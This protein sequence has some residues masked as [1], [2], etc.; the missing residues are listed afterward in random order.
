ML[1]GAISFVSAVTGDCPIGN[2]CRM[3]TLVITPK[4]VT[5]PARPKPGGVW[6]LNTMPFVII[7]L[8]L[9][10]VIVTVGLVV[11]AFTVNLPSA[12]LVVAETG[13]PL[14]TA[15]LVTVQV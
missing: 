6:P 3:V 11:S 10:P 13:T 14:T 1:P 7:A 8:A 2:V 9:G 4:S 15:L 12:L 5:T